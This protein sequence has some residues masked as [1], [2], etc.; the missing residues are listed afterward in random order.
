MTL[1]LTPPRIREPKTGRKICYDHV[2]II[3]ALADGETYA[4]Y[5]RKVGRSQTGV[6]AFVER[7]R[8]QHNVWTTAQL[9]AHY[10]RNGW[11]D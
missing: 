4:S 2:L 5:A 3:Q 10:L 9:V 11:I 8:T 7:L 6:R 1:D